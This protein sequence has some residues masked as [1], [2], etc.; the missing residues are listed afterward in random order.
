MITHPHADIHFISVS[1]CWL[2]AADVL[3]SPVS[4]LSHQT[5]ITDDE[6]D[7]KEFGTRYRDFKNTHFQDT[8]FHIWKI[9]FFYALV[10]FM[11]KFVKLRLLF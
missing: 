1:G 2:S 10:R 7:L 8:C 3:L 6:S 5:A 11:D 4:L 9:D